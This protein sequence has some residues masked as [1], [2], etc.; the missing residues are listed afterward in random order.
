MRKD[1]HWHSILQSYHSQGLDESQMDQMLLA[2][3]EGLV[4]ED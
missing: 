3:V 1:A 2:N 4:D